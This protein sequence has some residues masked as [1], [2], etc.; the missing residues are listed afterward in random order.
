MAQTSQ[1][2]DTAYAAVRKYED[3]ILPQVRKSLELSESAYAAGELDF[4]QVLVVRRSYYEATVR[5]IAVRRDLA[6]A[7]AKVDGLLLT[8]GL[9]QPADYTDGD[10]I[11]GAAIGGQ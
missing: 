7:T 4:L 10:G 11:R 6:Q 5:L 8:G 1:A 3:E 9:D 2:H